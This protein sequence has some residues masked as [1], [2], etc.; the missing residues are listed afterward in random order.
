MTLLAPPIPPTDDSPARMTLAEFIP[1]AEAMEAKNPRQYFEL[2]NGIP[3]KKPA[4]N[5]QH[6]VTTMN[7]LSP[8][9]HHAKETRC[10]RV[11]NN[12]MC[13]PP[14]DGTNVYLPDISYYLDNARP[15]VT[16]GSV[17][18]LP[19]LAIEVKSP[20]NTYNEL[21]E[22]AHYYLAKGTKMVW[23]VYSAKR[24]VEVLTADDFELLNESD[25]LTAEDLLPD[26]ALPV[27]DIFAP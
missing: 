4:P 19:D 21:R 24:Q 9:W 11:V 3:K 10:G 2:V 5:E 16:Q 12:V 23:L 14:D 8:L 17:P 27:R 25:T 7:V 6:G 13:N 20:R 22:R 26:F 15:V 18:L 1:F